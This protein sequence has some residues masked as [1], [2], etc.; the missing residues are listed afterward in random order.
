MLCVNVST[1]EE[2]KHYPIEAG[3]VS[4]KNM[5]AGFMPFGLGKGRGVE[6]QTLINQDVLDNFKTEIIGL[7]NEIL[8]QDIVFKE[9]NG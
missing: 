9:V 7:I 4:F 2:Y 8:N 5:K 3:I 1:K 6:T